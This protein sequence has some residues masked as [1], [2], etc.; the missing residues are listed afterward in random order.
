VLIQHDDSTRL[1]SPVSEITA[2][3]LA[4]FTWLVAK[5]SHYC[6]IHDV[7]PVESY[8][9]LQVLAFARE[10]KIAFFGVSNVYKVTWFSSQ[11]QGITTLYFIFL[12]AHA[13]EQDGNISF[14]K[15]DEI[16]TDF[17]IISIHVS[18]RVKS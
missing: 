2:I 3:V 12:K 9:I 7:L 4:V 18:F 16:T 14:S 13:T 6:F 15:L 5:L 10:S 11:W 8:F 1:V 17:K